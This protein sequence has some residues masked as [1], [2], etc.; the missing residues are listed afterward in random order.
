MKKT[1]HAT[2]GDNILNFS[3]PDSW[4]QLTQEQLRYVFYAMSHF[5]GAQAKTYI[6]VRLLAIRV[7]Q[8]VADGWTCSVKLENRKR[9]HFF[10]SDWQIQSFLRT[11]DFLDLPSETPICLASIG[12][13]KA[14]NV[15]LRGVPFHDYIRVENYYQGYLQTND[16]RQLRAIAKILYVDK[17]GNHPE[18]IHFTE[19]ELLSVFLWYA[20]LKNHFA[21][22]FPHFFGRVGDE[23]NV[24]P[25]N[26]V[27]V[28]N[29]EIRALT[30]GDVT[31][32][33]QV[34]SMDC[35]RALTELNEKAREIKEW[36][37]KY[38]HN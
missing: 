15:L 9:I 29:A 13:L 14:V 27:E 5:D 6:F 17:N 18:E 2:F 10:L 36:N 25:P 38:G 23:Q 21:I 34:L 3:L 37:E 24:E 28:M 26:M 19:A 30:G 7:F 8:K 11:L 4:E 16:V 20:S 32:E 1:T 35:W 22:S 33:N 31:K 12:K